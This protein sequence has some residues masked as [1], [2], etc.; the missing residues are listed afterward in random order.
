M[1]KRDEA[2]FLGWNPALPL[3]LSYLNIHRQV[4]EPLILSYFSFKL[5]LLWGFKKYD[6][7]QALSRVPSP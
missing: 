5:G 4:T 3:K 7:Y 2:Y 1:A 6:V